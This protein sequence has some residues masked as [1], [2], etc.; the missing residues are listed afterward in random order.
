MASADKLRYSGFG[1][2]KDTT[3]SFSYAP[4]KKSR[5]YQEEYKKKAQTILADLFSL[6]AK[7]GMRH[8][9]DSVFGAW[10]AIVDEEQFAFL[11][12]THN[13]YEE[14]HAYKLLTE[15]RSNVIAL[16]SSPS[17]P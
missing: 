8:R 15:L 5:A 3:L 1:S 9:E 16:T 6:G 13:T 14:R 4:D 12:L 2:I 7:P 10:Y 17:N 11:V